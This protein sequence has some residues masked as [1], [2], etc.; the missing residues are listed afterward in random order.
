MEA[1]SKRRALVG[2]EDGSKSVKFY[3]TETRSVL[4]SRNYCFLEP[5]DPSKAIPEE[6]LIA[7]DNAVHEGESMGNA[8]NTGDAW[9]VDA[10]PVPLNPQKRTAEDDA[11]GSP[12]KTRGK[13]V[14]YK[15]LDDPF[16]DDETM[17]AE[18]LTNLLE[19]DPDQPT[20]DQAK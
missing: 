12:R 3:N 15:H 10:K 16:S 13:R 11:E 17:S 1:K 2:Y 7:P 6:L 5:S 8:Q 20:F 19:G 4:T 9:N 18:E 14:D